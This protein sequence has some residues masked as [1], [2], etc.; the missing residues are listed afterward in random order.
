[1]ITGID[2]HGDF[3]GYITGVDTDGICSGQDN[4]DL[5]EKSKIDQISFSTYYVFW[6]KV[7]NDNPR[8]LYYSGF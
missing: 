5:I 3:L 7:M 6:I 1:M 4:K 8:D 2:Q